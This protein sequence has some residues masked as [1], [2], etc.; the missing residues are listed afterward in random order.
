MHFLTAVNIDLFYSVDYLLYIIFYI[1]I[2][3]ENLQYQNISVQFM[4]KTAASVSR[5]C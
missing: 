4:N 1:I 2:K 5:W 3:I